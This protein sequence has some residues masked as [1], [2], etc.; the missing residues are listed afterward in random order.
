MSA[1]GEY[2]NIHGRKPGRGWRPWL[3]IPKY[4]AAAVF[5]GGLVSLF[6]L[7]FLPP[8]PT[9]QA[10]WA[11]LST[12]IHDA[13]AFVIVP[14]LLGA[15]I[16]GLLLALA[17]PITFIR[18]RW[19]QVKLLLLA[20]FVPTLHVFMSHRSIALR[21]AVAREDFAAAATLRKELLGGTLTAIAF[22]LLIIVLGRIK[23][24]LRQEYGRTF[25]Q[26]DMK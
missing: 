17:H 1:S 7:G 19:L 18:M 22:A 12:L 15:L 5:L 21:D 6:V 14:G 16:L 10:D 9:T 26:K 25:G 8:A 11:R 3:L 2:R 24:R 23:P 20:V 13:Y 4:S